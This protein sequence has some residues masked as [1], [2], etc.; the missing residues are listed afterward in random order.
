MFPNTKSR[1]PDFLKIERR[2]LTGM[3]DVDTM[4]KALRLAWIPRLLTPE[5][6]HWKTIP[7]YYLRKF[8]GL[9]FLLSCNYDV[10]YIDSLPLF[11]KG[12]LTS[13]NELKTLHSF[14]GMQDVILI[15]NKE[16]SS[17]QNHF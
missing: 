13:F 3:T 12:I 11:Y 17:E 16:I 15:N 7:D 4:I 14:Y 1:E 2:W 9:N 6:R 10:K 5:I 8:G